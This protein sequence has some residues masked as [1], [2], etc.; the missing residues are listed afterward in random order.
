M[1]HRS[2]LRAKTTHNMTQ[3]SYGVS[4]YLD[5]YARLGSLT[6]P[7]ESDPQHSL[8]FRCDPWYFFYITPILTRAEPFFAPTGLKLVTATGANACLP[9]TSPMHATHICDAYGTN[10]ENVLSWAI[11]NGNPLGS[12]DKFTSTQTIDL[13]SSAG[14]PSDVSD[15]IDFHYSSQTQR[16]D[17]IKTTDP[18]N[19]A[20][21]FNEPLPTGSGEHP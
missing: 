21:V 20:S 8:A 17:V 4:T 3:L 2:S 15:D 1:L 14:T 6:D 19:S 16:W 12:T 7:T 10:P 13:R 11:V 9:A 18:W 5:T